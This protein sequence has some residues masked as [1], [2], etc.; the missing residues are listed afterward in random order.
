MY[1]QI[2][3]YLEVSLLFWALNFLRQD[4]KLFKKQFV[5]VSVISTFRNIR[6]RIHEKKWICASQCADLVNG[7]ST[8]V[9][10]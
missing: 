10:I 7:P 6:G 3:S 2:D 1:F 4:L 5:G 9:E 8:F